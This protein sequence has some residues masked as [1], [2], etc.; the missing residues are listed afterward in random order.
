M[1]K[2]APML[3][4]VIAVLPDKLSAY[5][6]LVDELK[7]TL[8][9]RDH[10]FSGHTKTVTFRDESRQADNL[11]ENKP[12]P[13]NVPQKLGFTTD[14][15]SRALDVMATR[16]VGNQS[17]R[18]DI[19]IDGVVV[20]SG[21]PATMLLTLEQR[22]AKL[23][24]VYAEIPTLDPSISWV[25]DEQYGKGFWRSV[26]PV[27]TAK[28][29][30]LMQFKVLYPATDKHPAQ[31]EKW[32]EDRV[33]ADVEAKRYSGAMSVAD[34]ADLLKRFDKLIEAVKAARIRANSVPVEPVAVAKPLF[35]Y[36]HGALAQ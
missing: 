15:L 25:P 33:V 17:A 6:K 9:K 21:V 36:I 27:R 18:A 26:D 19:E 20:V 1:A 34:K 3:H 4:E 13:S 31:I 23:R 2:K 35:D 5:D 22:L 12:V 10:L 8:G 14:E 28:T 32:F 16:D 11:V 29:E 30:K 24:A 7:G